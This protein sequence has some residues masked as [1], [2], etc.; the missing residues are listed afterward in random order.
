MMGGETV[1]EGMGGGKG[2]KGERQEAEAKSS[3]YE[4]IFSTL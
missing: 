1:R 4:A 2:E 3:Y